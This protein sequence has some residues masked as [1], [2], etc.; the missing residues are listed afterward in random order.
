MSLTWTRT[1]P[2]RMSEAPRLALADTREI[3]RVQRCP[4][5]GL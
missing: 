2:R 1:R 3:L 5:Y 4:Q